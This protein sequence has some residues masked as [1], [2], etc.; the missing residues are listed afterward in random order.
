MPRIAAAHLVIWLLAAS[1]VSGQSV[2]T[3]LVT[4]D[5]NRLRTPES[6]AFHILGF[7]PSS[8]ARPTS[9][10]A[11]AFS[12]LNS[13][14][15]QEQISLIPS[16]FAVEVN[17]YWW[18]SHPDLSFREYQGGGIRNLYRTLTLSLATADSS[19]DGPDG[20]RSFRRIALGARANLFGTQQEPA[21]VRDMVAIL[22]RLTED[23]GARINAEILRDPTLRDAARIEARRQ[24]IFQ[25]ALASLSPADEARLSARGRQQCTDDVADRH[26]F[27]VSLAAAA[28]FGFLEMAEPGALFPTPEGGL[29]TLGLWITPSWLSGR[30]SAIGVA[31]FV[32]RDMATD[33]RTAWDVGARAVYSYGRYAASAEGLY[34][35]RDTGGDGENEYRLATVFDIRVSTDLWLTATFGRDFEET[36]GSGLIALANL[37]WNIG[38]PGPRPLPLPGS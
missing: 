8:I 20:A 1:A 10:K 12:F 37:Q 3:T 25:E 19:I 27:V 26:G 9:P 2:D 14:R 33:T 30:F 11:F 24:Q 5:F 13:L 17:P 38:K 21:C 7:A 18:A 31:R 29:N 15:E 28:G 32:W 36:G 4:P 6:P 35:R 34:R 16:N 23:V 22:R